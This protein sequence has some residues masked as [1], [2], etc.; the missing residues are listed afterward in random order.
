MKFGNHWKS[1]TKVNE[2]Q[3]HCKNIGRDGLAKNQILNLKNDK[4]M[5]Y[6]EN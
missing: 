1:H 4:N 6:D 3:K 2:P 5:I